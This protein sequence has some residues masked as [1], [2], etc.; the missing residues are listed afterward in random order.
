MVEERTPAG[1]EREVLEAV[2]GSK[3]CGG[4]SG[5]RARVGGAVATGVVGGT[6]VYGA[7]ADTVT[8][9]PTAGP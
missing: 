4:R 8:T 6:S 5:S 7:L 1:E 9:L 2:V 3:W